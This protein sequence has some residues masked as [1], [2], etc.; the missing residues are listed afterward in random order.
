MNDHLRHIE[1]LAVNARKTAGIDKLP[2]DVS[3]IAEK[4]GLKVI[5]FDFPESFSGVLKKEHGAIGVNKNHSLV[6]RRFT[7]AHE[8]GH[9]LLGHQ[10]DSIDDQLDKPMPLE[11]EAN[12]FASHL[13]MPT[14]LIVKK[15][16]ETGIDLE[17]FAK[18]FL[19]SKQAMTI[20]LLEMN[21]IK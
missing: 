9:F 8:L 7:I 17:L 20:R 18:E 11:R 14:D 2:V 21:L 3:L 5:D 13:L 6:R 16:G 1:A 4:L 15:V 19:V 10:E 12:T